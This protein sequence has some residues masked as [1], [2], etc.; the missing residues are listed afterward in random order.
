MSD[1]VSAEGAILGISCG[2]WGEKEE[3]SVDC[4]VQEVGGP[5]CMNGDDEKSNIYI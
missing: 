2:D 3:K 4:Q 1:E 5:C